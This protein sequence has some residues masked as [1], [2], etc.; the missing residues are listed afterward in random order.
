[1]RD[2]KVVRPAIHRAAVAVADTGD[3][4]TPGTCVKAENAFH[5]AVML[6]TSVAS[7]VIQIALALYDRSEVLMGTSEKIV[8]TADDSWVRGAGVYVCP[9]VVFDLMGAIK[10]RVLV[11]SIS[12]GTVDI[13]TCP[14]QIDSLGEINW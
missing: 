3:L 10:Y 4:A 6:E 11:K 14:L 13:Y 7:A 2:L 5:A 12:T 1:M 9:V 8:V